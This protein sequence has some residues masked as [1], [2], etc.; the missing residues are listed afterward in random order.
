MTVVINFPYLTRS[1]DLVLSLSH[2]DTDGLNWKASSKLSA[3]DVSLSKADYGSDDFE[4]ADDLKDSHHLFTRFFPDENVHAGGTVLHASSK[5]FDELSKGGATKID[6]VD[7]P[8]EKG[9]VYTPGVNY[10]RKN[11]R[12]TLQTVGRETMRVVVDD[13]PVMLKVLHASGEL[14]ARDLTRKYEFWWL[15]DP[16]VRLLMRMKS[17]DY[18]EF[19]VVRIDRPEPSEGGPLSGKIEGALSGIGSGYGGPGDLR[20]KSSDDG[21][22]LKKRAVLPPD[23]KEAKG[24]P[25]KICHAPLHGVYFSTGSAEILAPSQPALGAVAEMLRRHADWQVQ[26]EGHT[27]NVGGDESNMALSKSRA[28]SVKNDL[29]SR[30]GISP[31]RI[32]TDGFG[33]K[34]PVDSNDTPDGRARNRRVEMTRRC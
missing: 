27:D 18:S 14:K 34:H 3:A 26:I 25:E 13:E 20:G 5:V 19:R 8:G 28:A 9:M 6:V 12:G 4:N 22:R 23:D 7:I 1:P 21:G 31:T 11:F 10:E 33:R 2:I 32:K 15:D 16:A 29:T 17:E 30:Y 24:P